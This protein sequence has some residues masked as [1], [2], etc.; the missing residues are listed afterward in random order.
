MEDKK[1]FALQAENR[2]M[3]FFASTYGS[4]MEAVGRKLGAEGQK[5]VYDAYRESVK[6]SCTPS[7]KK[8]KQLDAA[9]YA[10]WL[11]DDMMLGYDFEYVEKTPKSVRLRI[12]FCPLAKFF[13]EKGFAEQAKIFCDV[14]YDMI[15]DF[16]EATGAKLAFE[17]DKTLIY[18][19]GFCNHHIYVKE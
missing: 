13:R 5:L 4:L 3:T 19:D 14:D 7:W 16:N 9:A 12:K 11:L 2:V 8:M 6:K 1:T 10:D 17:R 15:K 18:G